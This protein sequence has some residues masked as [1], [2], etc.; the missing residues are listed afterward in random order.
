[1]NFRCYPGC[2]TSY[3]TAD[4]CVEQCPPNY[5]LKDNVCTAPSK[6]CALNQYY[7]S[8]S[9]TC[10]NCRSPC[11]TCVGA[12]HKCTSCVTNYYLADNSCFPKTNIAC[13]EKCSTCLE[14]NV[15]AACAS[16]YVN[17]GDDCVKNLNVLQEVKLQEISKTIRGSTVF[18]QVRPTIIPNGLPSTISSQFFILSPTQGSP[19]PVSSNQWVSGNDVYVAITYAGSIPNASGY[20]VPNMPILSDLYLNMGYKLANAFILVNISPSLPAAPSSL[21]V[22]LTSATV[23]SEKLEDNI[24]KLNYALS[25]PAETAAKVFGRR[26][27]L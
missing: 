2:P 27:A 23:G 24:G 10:Y 7:D 26:F 12:A 8:V 14:P 1:M 5:V 4:A 16:G 20:L 21:T 6:E 3:R 17:T 25:L 11:S 13:P 19:A 18:I 22:P 15:C 9:N